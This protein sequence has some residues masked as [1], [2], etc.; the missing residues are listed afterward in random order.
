[1]QKVCKDHGDKLK[2][3]DGK[4]LIEDG[5]DID[6]VLKMLADY[7]KRG[8]VSGKVFCIFAGKQIPPNE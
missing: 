2:I 8:E 5:K 1:M 7:Y 4:L 3:Q 6:V